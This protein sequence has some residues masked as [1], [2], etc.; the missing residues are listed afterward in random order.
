[1]AWQHLQRQQL[2]Y[3]KLQQD[4]Q[5]L[6]F[7][8]NKNRSKTSYQLQQQSLFDRF[9]RHSMVQMSNF[10]WEKPRITHFNY[11]SYGVMKRNYNNSRNSQ[12]YGS[13]GRGLL[14]RL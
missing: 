2:R 7:E 3:Q 1:M 9:E 8:A 6:E 12:H 13:S 4:M 10:F 14:Y 11:Y 5:Q